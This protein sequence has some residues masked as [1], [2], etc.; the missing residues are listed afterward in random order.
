M[1]QKIKSHPVGMTQKI[2]SYSVGMTVG[3]WR[4]KNQRFSSVTLSAV[5]GAHEEGSFNIE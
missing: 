3:R 2:K 1:T 5:E 4:E